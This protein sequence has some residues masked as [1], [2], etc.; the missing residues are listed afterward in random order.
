MLTDKQ[1]QDCETNDFKRMI[2]RIKKNYPKYKFI[3]TGDALYATA[4]IIKLCKNYKWNYF[5]LN[6]IY[7]LLIIYLYSF[8]LNF[9]ILNQPLTIKCN[10]CTC[11]ISNTINKINPSIL[12]HIKWIQFTICRYAN[13]WNPN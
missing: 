1:K 8:L 5:L 6:S 10:Y 9:L 3:I 11:R 2:K 4:P 7:F 13:N 12:S